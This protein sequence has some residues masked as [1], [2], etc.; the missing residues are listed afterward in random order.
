[1]ER[2]HALAAGFCEGL[3]HINALPK[4]KFLDLNRTTVTDGGLARLLE[5]PQLTN[6]NLYQ[7]GVTD[8][9][10]AAL[11]GRLNLTPCRSLVV[12]GPRVTMSGVESLRQKL[13]STQIIGPDLT[14]PKPP[15]GGGND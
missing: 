5:L 15:S 6:L 14:W 3:A 7:T 12:S 1:M 13:P 2:W 11:A 9:G 8:D 4:L 10:L